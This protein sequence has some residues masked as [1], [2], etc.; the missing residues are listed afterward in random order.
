MTDKTTVP[1][2]PK[3]PYVQWH[4]RT[5]EAKVERLKR[6]HDHNALTI[7]ELEQGVAN[8]QSEVMRLEERCKEHHVAISKLLDFMTAVTT[9]ATTRQTQEDARTDRIVDA[10]HKMQNGQRIKK[11]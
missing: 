5:L 7:A 2:D 10:L 8:L 6:V 9:E 1:I 4:N 11:R 3:E